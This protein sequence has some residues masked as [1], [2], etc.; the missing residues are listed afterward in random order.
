M[1]LL[2]VWWLWVWLWG[3]RSSHRHNVHQPFHPFIVQPDVSPQRRELKG[4]LWAVPRVEPALG[5]VGVDGADG[6]EV[7]ADVG[8][9]VEHAGDGDVA[10]MGEG[11]R[12]GG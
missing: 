10:R 5:M 7:F 2:W 3:C 8:G 6:E 9:D 12:G 1:W 11:G 4:A